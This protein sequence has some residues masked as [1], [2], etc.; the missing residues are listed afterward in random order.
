MRQSSN[1][2]E[3]SLLGETDNSANKPTIDSWEHQLWGQNGMP[4][5]FQNNIYLNNK[6][7]PHTAKKKGGVVRF[8]VHLLPVKHTQQEKCKTQGKVLQIRIDMSVCSLS[9]HQSAQGSDG[10]WWVPK[11]RAEVARNH[12]SSAWWRQTS[13]RL[14]TWKSRSN[15]SDL[16][17]L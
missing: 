5:I 14:A 16:P 6:M 9:P 15:V 12:V 2:R 17:C 8:W 10:A 3:T 13:C 11:D 4:D 1:L 7:D